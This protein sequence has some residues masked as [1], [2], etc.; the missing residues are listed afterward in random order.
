MSARCP[1]I[2][3]HLACH[4][5]RSEEP[6]NR[7]FDHTNNDAGCVTVRA[8]VSG[9]KY[10]KTTIASSLVVC[11]TRDDGLQRAAKVLE[12]VQSLFDYVDTGGVTEPDSAIVT[13]SSSRNHR[14][15]GFAQQAIGEILRCQTKLTDI[16][17]HVKCAL[18]F[19]CG[20]IGNL[21]D[22]VEHV[23]AA[24]IELFAHVD[25]RLLIPL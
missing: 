15:V 20:H 21:R 13:E 3:R 16:H 1:G 24:H 23:I 7:T 11:A 18:R 14:D 5:E 6:L 12:A 25:Q 9:R 22:A 8:T 2:E 4:S 19:D 10:P 17:Q